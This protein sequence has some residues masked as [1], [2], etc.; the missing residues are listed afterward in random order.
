MPATAGPVTRRFFRRFRVVASLGLPYRLALVV[1][2]I[3][4]IAA[5]LAV[6]MLHRRP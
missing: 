4:G 1:A 3:S 5:G 6:E 2:S